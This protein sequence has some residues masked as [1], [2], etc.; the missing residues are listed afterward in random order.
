MARKQREAARDVALM[1]RSLGCEAAKRAL[2]HQDFRRDLVGS[3]EPETVLLENLPRRPTADDRRR[4]GTV[5]T[6]RGSSRSARQIRAEICRIA[7]RT[8]MP[9]KTTSRQPSR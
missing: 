5:A 6:I 7:G 1:A 8:T 9:M 2:R 4:R 3:N